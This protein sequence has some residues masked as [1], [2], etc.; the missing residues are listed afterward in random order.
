MHLVPK[1][2]KIVTIDCGLYDGKFI[3]AHNMYSQKANKDPKMHFFYHESKEEL[4]TIDGLAYKPRNEYLIRTERENLFM[5]I[6]NPNE[7]DAELDKLF[8]PPKIKKS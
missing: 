7:F 1:K 3:T 4:Y 6:F 2:Y 5:D 8:T